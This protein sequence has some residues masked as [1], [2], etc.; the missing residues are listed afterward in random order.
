MRALRRAL[1]EVQYRSDFIDGCLTGTGF[2]FTT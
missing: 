1:R 2:G